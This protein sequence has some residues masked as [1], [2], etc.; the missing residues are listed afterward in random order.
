MKSDPYTCVVYEK[1]DRV[2]YITLNRPEV[3]NAMDLRM[4]QELALVWDDFES[5]DEVWL[6]VLTGAGHRSFSVGQDLKERDRLNRA[7]AGPTTFGSQGQPGWPR[8]TER[9][10]L[11]KPVIARVDGFALGGGFELALACDLIVASDRAVFALPE[12][13][14]GL[15]AGAGGVFRLARQIPLKSAMGYLMTGRNMTADRA[16]QLGLVNEVVSSEELDACV[17][18]WVEAL[19]RCAPLSLRA[20]KEAVTSSVDMPLPQAFAT[21]YVWEERRMHSL[22]AIEGPRAFAGKRTPVWRGK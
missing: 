10:A 21:R 1:K 14:L 17:G 20:I 18:R 11:S 8:L 7:G 12:A 9:F 3:L 22:D 2:A 15:I 5:D 6:A 19:L 13:K 16:L 4:H